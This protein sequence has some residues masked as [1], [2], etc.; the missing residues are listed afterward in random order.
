M[1]VVDVSV[2]VAD[3]FFDVCTPRGTPS[4]VCLR[5]FI[6]FRVGRFRVC[7]RVSLEISQ[8][9]PWRWMDLQLRAA[10]SW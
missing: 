8:D 2:V 10:E 5:C 9:P 7:V 6:F 1:V 4:G 3:V